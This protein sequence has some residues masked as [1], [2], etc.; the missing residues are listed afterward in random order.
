[1]QN[2]I[3]REIKASFDVNILIK[4]EDNLYIAH[5]LELDIVAASETL[6]QVQAEIID[7][8]CVQIDYA[9]SNDN[10]DNLFHPAPPELWQELY[11]CKEMTEIEH[12]LES[13]S[14]IK[15]EKR[16]IPPWLIAK[17]CQ[18]NTDQICHA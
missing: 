7:L 2:A 17:I 6:E 8:I 11:Q 12:P 14:D 1:M 13:V 18:S 9:F 15:K 10:L 16:L 3:K 5:C 4:Q